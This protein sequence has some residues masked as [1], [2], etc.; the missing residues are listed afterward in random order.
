MTNCRFIYSPDYKSQ[1]QNIYW[2]VGKVN[3]QWPFTNI[4][5]LYIFC[6]YHYYNFLYISESINVSIYLVTYRPIG[7]AAFC[8]FVYVIVYNYVNVCTSH[9]NN[10]LL[11]IHTFSPTCICYFCYLVQTRPVFSALDIVQLFRFVV[12]IVAS[13]WWLMFCDS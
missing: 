10:H 13:V 1:T 2:H 3:C 8:V 7:P 9:N 12:A 4:Y 6:H 5:S 11:T